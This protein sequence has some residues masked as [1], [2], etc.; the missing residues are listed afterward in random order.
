MIIEQNLLTRNFRNV[1]EAEDTV[2]QLLKDSD[3]LY[4]FM[5][6]CVSNEPSVNSSDT[7]AKILICD[8][9]NIRILST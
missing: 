3:G 2:N 4:G 8:K 5:E 7:Y 1:K 6:K 9:G